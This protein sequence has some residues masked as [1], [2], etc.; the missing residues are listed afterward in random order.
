MLQA[1]TVVAGGYS[2]GLILLYHVYE[3]TA[4]GAGA[5]TSGFSSRSAISCGAVQGSIPN[6]AGGCGE[7]G[8]DVDAVHNGQVVI[9]D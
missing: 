9:V 5:A 1:M 8:D 4:C 2:H 3:G 6:Y 7:A